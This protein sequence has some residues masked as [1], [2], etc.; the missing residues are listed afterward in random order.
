MA[1]CRSGRGVLRAETARER[2]GGV[3]G[4]VAMAGIERLY[5]KIEHPY[6]PLREPA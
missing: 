2:G 4:R 3:A 5:K 6:K 1:I